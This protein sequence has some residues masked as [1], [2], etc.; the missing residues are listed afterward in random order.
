MTASYKLSLVRA[1]DVIA[2][3]LVVADKGS[4]DLITTKRL[5]ST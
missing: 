5:G 4:T 1:V 2:R 3:V